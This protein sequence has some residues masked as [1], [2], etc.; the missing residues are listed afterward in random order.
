MGPVTA[1]AGVCLQDIERGAHEGGKR[2]LAS[3]LR[4]VS[5]KSTQPPTY[6]PLH[7]D[8]SE[9]ERK[10]A[11]GMRRNFWRAH[12]VEGSSMTVSSVVRLVLSEW[13]PE[14]GPHPDLD[15]LLMGLR[16]AVAA[17]VLSPR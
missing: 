1:L 5:S 12:T 9:F 4:P 10:A 13:G 6:L 2:L 16:D 7:T 3:R 17:W 14:G 11:A 15:I 8:R